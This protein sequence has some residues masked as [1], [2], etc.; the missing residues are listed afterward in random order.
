MC[1]SLQEKWFFPRHRGIAKHNGRCV[2]QRYLGYW[3]CDPV[4][5]VPSSPIDSAHFYVEMMGGA[6]KMIP[7]RKELHDQGRYMLGQE[8]L[9]KLV[10]AEP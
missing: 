1:Y 5:L 8:I 9:N 10:Q 6:E 2:V 3:D 7:R 4:T